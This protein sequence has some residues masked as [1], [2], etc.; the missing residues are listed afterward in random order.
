MDRREIHVSYGLSVHK[1]ANEIPIISFLI[2]K[3]YMKD[4]SGVRLSFFLQKKVW[5][6][7]KYD[8]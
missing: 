4:H 8:K 5:P 3:E 6:M 1:F 7:I 2:S